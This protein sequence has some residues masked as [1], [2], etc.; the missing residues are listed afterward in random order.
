[1]R[2]MITQAKIMMRF[3]VWAYLACYKRAELWRF[4][5]REVVIEGDLP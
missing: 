2:L 3:W 5:Y 4:R 1:V